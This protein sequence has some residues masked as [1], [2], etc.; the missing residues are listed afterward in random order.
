[1]M[2]VPF[3]G[4]HFC[5]LFCGLNGLFIEECSN[6]K[7]NFHN[8]FVSLLNL[9]LKKTKDKLTVDQHSFKRDCQNKQFM[10][11]FPMRSRKNSVRIWQIYEYQNNREASDS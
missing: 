9:D 1:M 7:N 4:R 6:T 3:V 5:S 2:G 8:I 11:L 10:M